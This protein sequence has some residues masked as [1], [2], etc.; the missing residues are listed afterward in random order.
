[1]IA[2]IIAQR[3]KKEVNERP[4]NNDVK[5][6]MI[7]VCKRLYQEDKKKGFIKTNYSNEDEFLKD[8]GL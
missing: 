1:M 7:R 3:I 6:G 2:Q 8:C 4:I 5:E